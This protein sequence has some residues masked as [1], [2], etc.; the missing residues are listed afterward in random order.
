MDRARSAATTLFWAPPGG[1]R[2]AVGVGR[3]GGGHSARRAIVPRAGRA[4]ATRLGLHGEL[5]VTL[6]DLLGVS[7]DELLGRAARSSRGTAVKNR[8]LLRRIQEIDRLPKHDQ[9]ALLRTIDA[10]PTRAAS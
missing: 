3:W 5:I 10:F 1:G 9:Q 4:H 6:A 7:A 2:R 8:R